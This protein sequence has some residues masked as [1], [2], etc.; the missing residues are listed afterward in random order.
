MCV[1]VGFYGIPCLGDSECYELGQ[2]LVCSLDA[3]PT[4]ECRPGHIYNQV[5]LSCRGNYGVN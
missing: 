1:I 3:F 4:C 2:D 5:S